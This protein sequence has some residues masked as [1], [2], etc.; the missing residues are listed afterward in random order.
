MKSDW[1]LLN[2][3]GKKS[4]SFSMVVYSF[5]LIS[6]WLFCYVV[7][8]MFGV[9]IPAFDATAAMAYFSPIAALY[10]FRKH[11][12]RKSAPIKTEEDDK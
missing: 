7:L 11:E 1:Y 8:S 3:E 9:S 2:D 5:F 4:L 6:L 10:G 12:K